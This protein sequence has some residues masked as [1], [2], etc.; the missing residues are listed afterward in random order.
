MLERKLR[1]EDRREEGSMVRS[2]VDRFSEER[3]DQSMVTD[4]STENICFLE[5]GDT[6]EMLRHVRHATLSSRSWEDTCSRLF[7]VM[8]SSSRLSDQMQ[9]QSRSDIWSPVR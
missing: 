7:P 8:S 4:C 3:V 1:L 6:E 5:T 2:K 9:E